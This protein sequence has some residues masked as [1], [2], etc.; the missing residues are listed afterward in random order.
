MDAMCRKITKDKIRMHRGRGYMFWD[1]LQSFH[2]RD[3]KKYLNLK[4]TLI[5]K[6]TLNGATSIKDS[7]QS[8]IGRIGS[9]TKQI[10]SFIFVF[11]SLHL[12]SGVHWSCI[13]EGGGL[14]YIQV[15]L[16]YHNAQ[17]VR[18]TEGVLK[19]PNKGLN[20]LRR[21][22]RKEEEQEQEADM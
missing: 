15:S 17:W 5:A 13:K 7:L 21:Q 18:H 12:P 19:F 3:G 11:T 2:P 8:N 9:Q 20:V 22:T 14:A 6:N 4:Y 10:L 1:I 16:K